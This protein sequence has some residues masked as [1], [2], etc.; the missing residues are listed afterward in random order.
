MAR[1]ARDFRPVQP[2][3]IPSALGPRHSEACLRSEM[4]RPCVRIQPME[5]RGSGRTNDEEAW[6]GLAVASLGRAGRAA[7]HVAGALAAGRLSSAGS[8][9][10]VMPWGRL[11]A[12]ALP[13][14]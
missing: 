3:R 12:C 4:A 7:D 13:G 10:G 11:C 2:P 5:G 1:E 9:P 8:I 6:R 14:C